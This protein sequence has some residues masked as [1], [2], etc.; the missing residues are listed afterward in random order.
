MAEYYK[1]YLIECLNYCL[2]KK[3]AAPP[4][5]DIDWEKFCKFARLHGVESNMYF[6][7]KNSNFIAPE[8]LEKLHEAYD[9][10]CEK[11]SAENKEIDEVL[12]QFRQ[13][14]IPYMLF[15]GIIMRKLYPEHFMRTSADID[16]YYNKGYSGVVR[17]ILYD[18]DYSITLSAIDE[19]IYQNP[20]Y[21]T[22]LMHKMLL[23]PLTKIGKHYDYRPFV[24]GITID[25]L[26]YVMGNDDFYLFHFCHLAQHFYDS[27]AG[28]KFFM[29]IK[30]MRDI[31]DLDEEYIQLKLK[32]FKLN[33]FHEECLKL[34]DYW[35]NGKECDEVSRQFEE[36][37]LS[38][39]SYGKG[40]IFD[41]NR[42]NFGKK[43]RYIS[44]VF[45]SAKRLS[46]HYPEI[47]GKK[48]LV[49]Y[50]WVKRAFDYKG[51][52]KARLK[53][54]GQFDNKDFK[55]LREFYSKIGL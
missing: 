1:K 32:K 12:A 4:K 40:A 19:D 7:L 53:D 27:G 10:V 22:I 29:D 20:P 5:E 31:F 38:F 8:A 33:K 51:T 54:V 42:T 34:A 9:R 24:N 55:E 48:Y 15:K 49:P 17:E 26:E 30:V 11:Q 43:N 44:A 13:S 46:V 6:A 36:H 28:I 25:G 52:I 2:K 23:S 3:D 14:N 35:F 50:Y 21:F 18:R 47:I 39:R 41:F 45:P 16:I 37:V